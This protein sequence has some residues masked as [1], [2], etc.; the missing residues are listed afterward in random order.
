MA[1][2]PRYHLSRD[3]VD[4]AWRKRSRQCHPDRFA[5]GKAVERRM[6]IQW[7]ASI[8][9]AR[10]VLRDPVRRAWYL[11]TGSSRPPERGGPT[12]APEF[13][14][15]IFELRMDAE[16]DPEQ[17]RSTV[18][19]N[20]LQLDG[21]LDALFSSWERDEGDL[22]VVPERLSRLKYID[23]LLAELPTGA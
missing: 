5:G 1:L 21:E 20:K 14:E 22:S 9:D 4:K 7:T 17:V 15:F 8:N 19:E 23:N 13:L 12:L 18:Q 3:D 2:E 16:D 10:R 6:A 11:A